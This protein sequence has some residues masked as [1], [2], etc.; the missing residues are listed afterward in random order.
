MLF[1]VPL[2]VRLAL[3]LARAVLLLSQGICIQC[4]L[5]KLLGN[6]KGR[7]LEAGNRLREVQQISRCG[8]L[9]DV[10]S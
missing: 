8:G 5:E 2:A 3:I 1:G 10:S 6:V 4:M 9:Q 7:L